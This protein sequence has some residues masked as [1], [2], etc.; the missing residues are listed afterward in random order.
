VKDSEAPKIVKSDPWFYPFANLA[1]LAGR[2]QPTS[3][4]GSSV[5]PFRLIFLMWLSFTMDFVYGINLDFLGI[6]PRTLTG[7]PGILTGPIIHG[8]LNHLISN[9]LPLLFLG[10]VLFFFYEPIGRRVFFQIYFIPNLL[11]WLFAR[12]ANHIG[13]SGLVYGLSIFL[14]VFGLT[15]RDFLSLTLS[16]VVLFFYGGLLYGVFTMDPRIS[17]EAHASGALVG[18][19]SAL[20]LSRSYR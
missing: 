10:S 5:V 11:V 16:A 17:W 15:R 20:T 12:P 8:S 14:I 19:V 6:V 9:T 4:F 18:T 2:M 13:A 1:I 3:L 7:L